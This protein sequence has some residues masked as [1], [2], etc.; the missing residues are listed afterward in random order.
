[1]RER[2]GPRELTRCLTDAAYTSVH[3]SFGRNLY[4][5]DETLVSQPSR[6]S[7]RAAALAFTTTLALIAGLLLLGSVVLASSTGEAANLNQCKNGAPSSHVACIQSTG[8]WQNGNLGATN[9]HYRENDSVPFQVLLTGMGGSNAGPHTLDINWAETAG[10]KHA[11][12]YLTSYNRTETTADACAGFL[13]FTAA[14]CASSHS[15]ITIGADPNLAGCAGFTGTQV[16]GV[17]DVY[18]ATG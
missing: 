10:S 16:S 6:V 14:T 1:K 7:A 15:T 2:V 4:V 5:S 9:S 8:A 17:I 3:P 18:G 13:G 12:D 11:Y